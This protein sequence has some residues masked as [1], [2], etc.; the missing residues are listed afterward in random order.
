M[1]R[2]ATGAAQMTAAQFITTHE[3]AIRLGAFLSIFAAMALWEVLAPRRMLG[4]SKRVRWANNLGLVVLNSV[5]IRLVFPLAATGMAALASERGW[6]LLNYLDA[7]SWLAV[8]AS[9]VAL[10]LAIYLQ[11]VM[12]HAVPALWRVHR[13]HHVDLNDDA[14]T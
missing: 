2:R 10:D 13:M 1:R 12:F 8:L 4:V 6:G 7:P 3:P 9:I 11:H 5:L 14:T